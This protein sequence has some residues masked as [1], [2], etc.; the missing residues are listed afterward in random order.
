MYIRRDAEQASGDGAIR[1]LGGRGKVPK[2]WG[3]RDLKRI[4][5]E[6]ERVGPYSR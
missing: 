2:K 4:D 3:E 1:K 5:S 6:G